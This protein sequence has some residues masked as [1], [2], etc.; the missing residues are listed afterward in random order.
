ML[1]GTTIWSGTE[2][3][4]KRIGDGEVV[5]VVVIAAPS[6]DKLIADG[7]LVAGGRV[8]YAKSG[9]GVA[10]RAGLPRPDI[11]S[12]EAVKRAVLAA[13]S[14]GYSSGPSGLYLVDLFKKMGI[15]DQIKDKVRQPPSGTQIADLMARGEVELGF[16]QISELV[17]AKGVDYLGPL[18]ADIQ[19]ITVF[20]AALH[21]AAPAAEAA[22]ALMKF[23][24]A[25]EAGPVVR[26]TGME[27]G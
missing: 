15:A 5:D 20:S 1:F 14:V 3:I 6:I 22:R 11:S 10:V 23:L 7:R 25:P 9:V 19:H 26:K 27:P 18:P 16:Q 4:V 13:K 12:G 2:S 8:D 21:A 17:H 24:T